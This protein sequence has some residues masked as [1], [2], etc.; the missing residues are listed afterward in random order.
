L[1]F[2]SLQFFFPRFCPFAWN[3]GI[4]LGAYFCFSHNSSAGNFFRACQGPH[5]FP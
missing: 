5:F 2:F 1:N 4:S 3:I